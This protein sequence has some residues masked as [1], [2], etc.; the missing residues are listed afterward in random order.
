[1]RKEELNKIIEVKK[2]D[3]E[4]CEQELHSRY[5]PSIVRLAMMNY[6]LVLKEQLEQ[7][8]NDLINLR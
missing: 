2:I 7:H 3:L 4:E 5:Y 6:I 1:M 8:N